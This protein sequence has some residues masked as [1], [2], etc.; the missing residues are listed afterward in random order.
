MQQV[1]EDAKAEFLR[2]KSRLLKG[3]ET[4]PDDKANWSPSPTSRTPLQLVGHCAASIPGIQGYLMGGPF[5]FTDMAEMDRTLREEDKGYTSREQV[6]KSL[7]DHCDAYI[8]WLDTLTPEE[9]GSIKETLMG[10]QPMAQMVTWVADHLRSHA[11]QLDYIQ[12]IY[13]DRKF[14]MG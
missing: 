3:L 9:V 6:K 13:G 12:T 4:T 10:P 2:A 8:V 14:Y 1:I 5:P 11:A 7:T